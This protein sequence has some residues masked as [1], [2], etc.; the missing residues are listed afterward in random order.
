[1]VRRVPHPD[2]PSPT[3]AERRQEIQVHRSGPGR[4]VLRV[5]DEV[6]ACTERDLPDALRQSLGLGIEDVAVAARVV[7]MARQQGV[8]RDLF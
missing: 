3:A 6:R 7:E 5:G 1:M 2:D 4:Y 8:G